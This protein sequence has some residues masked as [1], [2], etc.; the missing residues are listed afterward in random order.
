MKLDKALEKYKTDI[1]IHQGKSKHTIEGYMHDLNQYISFLKENSINDTEAV[2]Y[3]LILAYL[4]A[5]ESE[6]KQDTTIVRSMAAIRSFHQYLAFYEDEEDPSAPVSIHMSRQRLPIYCTEQEMKKLLTSFDDDNPKDFLYHVIFEVLYGCGLR[7][8][9]LVT[10]TLNRVDIPSS[11]LR[12]LGKGSKERIVPVPDY[13]NT[14]LKKYIEIYRPV[15][16]KK[17]TNLVFINTNGNPVTVRTIERHLLNKCAENGISKHITPHK[18]R[19]TYATHMLQ[20]GADLRSIQEILGHSDISTTEIYTHVD[21]EHL[22]QAYRQYH[23]SKLD[24]KLDMPEIQ[25]NKQKR[26][27]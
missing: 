14:L 10:L 11:T 16:L 2:S 26:K 3:E 25:F 22:Q 19:H 23:P 18:L 12:I 4:D 8:S 27:K 21:T 24:S 5:L 1:T 17:K 20:G 9:E 7:I 13:T 15:S 6:D